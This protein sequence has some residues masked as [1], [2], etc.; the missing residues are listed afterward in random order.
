MKISDLQAIMQPANQQGSIPKVNKTE[1]VALVYAM[2]TVRKTTLGFLQRQQRATTTLGAPAAALMPPPLPWLSEPGSPSECF[3]TGGHRP[4]LLD[5]A[6]EV[7]RPE[8]LPR[9]A[10]G[11]AS[12]G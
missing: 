6:V 5:S 10:C 2:L 9:D 11:A 7:L 12:D 4:T 3:A 1:L 8:P